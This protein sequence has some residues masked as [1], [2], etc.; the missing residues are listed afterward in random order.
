M[1]KSQQFYENIK[2]CISSR[3]DLHFQICLWI[4]GSCTTSLYKIFANVSIVLKYD[5]EKPKKND[6]ISDNA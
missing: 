2:W 6:S 1:E 4:R 5:H 3:L